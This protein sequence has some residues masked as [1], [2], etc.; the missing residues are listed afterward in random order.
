[1]SGPWITVE[2]HPFEILSEAPAKTLD[3]ARSIGCGVTLVF[4]EG[5]SGHTRMTRS[6]WRIGFTGEVYDERAERNA[7]DECRITTHNF[8]LAMI[9]TILDRED[10]WIEAYKDNPQ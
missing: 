4:R 9:E 8:P 2:R 3:A 7:C 6:D 5:Y 1:M 10:P